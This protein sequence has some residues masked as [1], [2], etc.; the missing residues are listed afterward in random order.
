MYYTIDVSLILWLQALSLLASYLGYSN[1]KLFLEDMLVSLVRKW[2]EQDRPL[3]EFPTTLLDF[4][5]P[6]DFF[7]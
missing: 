1:R 7:R 3:L 2:V 4:S 5:S 6:K